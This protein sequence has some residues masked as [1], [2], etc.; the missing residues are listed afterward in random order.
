MTRRQ[1][2]KAAALF[3]PPAAKS[4]SAVASSDATH[5]PKE[6]ASFS[7]RIRVPKFIQHLPVSKNDCISI[8]VLVFAES[9]IMKVKL[10]RI[11]FL[12]E[13]FPLTYAPLLETFLSSAG[14]IQQ[15]GTL[16]LRGLGMRK[17]RPAGYAGCPL[18]VAVLTVSSLATIAHSSGDSVTTPS[19]CIAS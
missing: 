4:Q 13:S 5:T 8:T 2:E 12:H 17:M 14:D 11:L 18:M 19:T 9:K 1:K 6:S 16:L 7:S 10:I 3:P 15:S